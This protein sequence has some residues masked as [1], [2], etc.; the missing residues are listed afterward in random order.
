[1]GGSGVGGSWNPGFGAIGGPI[2]FLIFCVVGV[3]GVDESDV[4]PFGCITKSLFDGKKNC[5]DIGDGVEPVLDGIAG[6][7]FGFGEMLGVTSES[8]TFLKGSG[9]FNIWAALENDVLN[10]RVFDFNSGDCGN[11]VD[12]VDGDCVLF[13]LFVEFTFLKI[14]SKVRC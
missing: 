8:L 7:T 4:P 12:G 6:S 1:M 9:D 5:G 11:G 10:F 13:N 2:F 14:S 3:G